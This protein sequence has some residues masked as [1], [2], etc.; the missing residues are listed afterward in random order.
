MDDLGDILA[1]VEIAASN[2]ATL[3]EQQSAR[4]ENLRAWIDAECKKA[5]DK[6]PTE[7]READL[8]KL[9][10]PVPVNEIGFCLRGKTGIGKTYAATA[11]AKA[12]YRRALSLEAR[13]RDTDTSASRAGGLIWQTCPALLSRIRSSFRN[14]SGETEAEIIAQYA[15]C[16]VLLLD[17][18]G[19]EKQT[20]FSAAILYAIISERRNWR[21]FTIITTNQNLEE[22]SAWEPR[23]ASRLAEM[24][25]ISLPDIDR[26]LM[27]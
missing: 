3:A 6:I 25:E 27:R 5:F 4:Q 20:D 17:D 15:R 8:K 2:S 24:A 9:Q 1:R 14:Q 10:C 23:L 18:V 11:I 13:Q 7:Y 19:A 26:R 22:I 12:A 21:R 16:A